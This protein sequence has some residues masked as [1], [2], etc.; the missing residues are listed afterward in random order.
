[1]SLVSRIVVNSMIVP[2]LRTNYSLVALSLF[3]CANSS[4]VEVGLPGATRYDS[5]IL[6]LLGCVRKIQILNQ[7]D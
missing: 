7:T 5:L 1:M 6:L 4:D 2:V 3:K